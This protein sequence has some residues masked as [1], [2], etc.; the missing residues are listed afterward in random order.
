MPAAL[1]LSTFT[2][3]H[4]VC[5]SG[6]KDLDLLNLDPQTLAV[7][8]S[9]LTNVKSAL[10]IFTGLVKANEGSAQTKSRIDAMFEHRAA[11]RGR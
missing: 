11:D 10:A 9:R 2:K 3:T 7:P 1:A 8:E 5:T 4:P 6:L